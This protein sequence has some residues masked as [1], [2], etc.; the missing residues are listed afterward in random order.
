MGKRD[1]YRDLNRAIAEMRALT[2]LFAVGEWV[3]AHDVARIAGIGTSQAAFALQRL[4]QDGPVEKRKITYKGPRRSKEE[5]T[6]Y[7]PR[8]GVD[9]V[10]QKTWLTLWGGW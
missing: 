5:S 10:A 3:R 4:A 1:Y 7:R 6:E 2:V 8:L 9:P